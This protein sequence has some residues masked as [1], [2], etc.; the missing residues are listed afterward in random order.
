M[1]ADCSSLPLYCYPVRENVIMERVTL[2]YYEPTI[3]D[4]IVGS[5]IEYVGR[6]GSCLCTAGHSMSSETRVAVAVFIAMK[7]A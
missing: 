4:G 3:P 1:L 5:R 6:N 2:L 7:C